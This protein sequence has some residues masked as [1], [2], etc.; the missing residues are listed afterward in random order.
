M[1]FVMLRQKELNGIFDKDVFK[2]VSILE[3]LKNIQIIHSRFM[4]KI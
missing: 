1:S 3:L 2:V 4:D